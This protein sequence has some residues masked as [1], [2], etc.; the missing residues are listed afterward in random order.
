MRQDARE[1]V[2]SL[3]IKDYK[4]VQSDALYKFT[5]DAVVLSR[6][7]PDGAATIAD[8]CAGSGIVGLHYFALHDDVVK[9][10]TC[11]EIQK[12][13]ADMC[14][15]S[16]ALNGL[17]DVFTVACQPLQTFAPKEKYDLVLC[18]PPYEKAGAGILPKDEH[19]AVCRT[20]LTVTLDEVTACAS[21]LLKRGGVFCI[22]HKVSRLPEVFLSF[23][24]YGLCP[25]RLQLVGGKS[26]GAYLALVEGVKG[27]K[28]EM[29]A[30]NTVINDFTDFSGDKKG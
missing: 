7:A 30:Y 17:E 29:R 23:D 19:I 4:I 24:K 1:K 11:V 3:N 20:E 26:G 9:K 25:S 15:K 16:V 8:L 28:V 6:F 12:P 10:V 18:N 27:K 2:E 14:F 21:R 5:S 22:C 13:L